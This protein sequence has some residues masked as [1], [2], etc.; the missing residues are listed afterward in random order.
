MKNNDNIKLT[1]EAILLEAL[2]HAQQIIDELNTNH[3]TGERD[4][5][6]GGDKQLEELYYKLND[7]CLTISERNEF[8]WNK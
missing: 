5:N 6:F 4:I 7:M 1:R 3:E 2:H 8:W